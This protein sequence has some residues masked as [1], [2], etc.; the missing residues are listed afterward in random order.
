MPPIHQK[1][2][3]EHQY[4]VQSETEVCKETL[5]NKTFDKPMFI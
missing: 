2:I 4:I 1:A 3:L 5:K